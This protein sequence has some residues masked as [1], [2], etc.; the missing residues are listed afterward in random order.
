LFF[1]GRSEMN[2]SILVIKRNATA[3]NE[4]TM[5][6]TSGLVYLG[7]ERRDNFIAS[8]S[9]SRPL[10]HLLFVMVE[11]ASHSDWLVEP[12][13]VELLLRNLAKWNL[14]NLLDV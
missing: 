11:N 1:I 5:E 14:I 3:V 9:I 4:D 13:I 10:N 6:S 7:I 8:F 12:F 2:S